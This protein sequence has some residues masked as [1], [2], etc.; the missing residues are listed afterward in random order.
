MICHPVSRV[1]V[2]W[3]LLLAIALIHAELPKRCY[4]NPEMQKE[5][6]KEIHQLYLDDQ[7]DREIFGN[8]SEE[9]QLAMMERDLKKR[10]RIGE[11]FAEGCINGASDYFES[12]IIFQHGD[13]PDHYFQAFHFAH[14]AES[15]GYKGA[16][17]LKAAAIDRYLISID[18]KQLFSTQAFSSMQTEGCFCVEQTETSFPDDLRKETTGLSLLEQ[19]AKIDELNRQNNKDCPKTMCSIEHKST[20]K[21]TIPGFW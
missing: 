21:N 6:S 8:A 12:A 20:P 14:K 15:L 5:R 11:I 2:F 4:F 3:G 7:K 18:H 16:K 1:L 10:M 9:E 13:V 17:W 19:I